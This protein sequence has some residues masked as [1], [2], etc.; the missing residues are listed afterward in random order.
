MAPSL[1]Q[2]MCIMYLVTAYFLEDIH[3]RQPHDSQAPE[4]IERENIC[5]LTSKRLYFTT[6]EP[7]KHTCILYYTSI[8]NPNLS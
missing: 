6:S 1:E 3:C 7:P 2:G 5:S 4:E 8:N